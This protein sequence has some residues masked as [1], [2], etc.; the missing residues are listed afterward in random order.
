MCRPTSNSY[1]TSRHAD[2]SHLLQHVN[3]LVSA[4]GVAFSMA[5]AAAAA[6]VP[7]VSPPP[8]SSGLPLFDESGLSQRYASVV[9]D[10]Q[11]TERQVFLL[12]IK[13]LIRYLD[14]VHETALRRRVKV[15]IFE[16]I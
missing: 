8:P 10:V 12:F 15:I 1:V 4:A 6:A 7:V 3:G 14:K 11:L 13:V 2:P 16:C 9:E 5:A